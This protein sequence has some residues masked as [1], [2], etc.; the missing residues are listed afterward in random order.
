MRKSGQI[1]GTKAAN[2]G[3]TVAAVMSASQEPKHSLTQ[4]AGRRVRIPLRPFGSLKSTQ[5]QTNVMNALEPELQISDW[6]AV[7]SQANLVLREVFCND[8]QVGTNGPL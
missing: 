6:V 1:A 3:S 5:P 7:V 2:T 8:V 4:T